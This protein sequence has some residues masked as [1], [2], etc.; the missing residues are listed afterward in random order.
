[1][2]EDIKLYWA[3]RRVR[4]ARDEASAK[5]DQKIAEAKAEGASAEAVHTVKYEANCDLIEFD[6]EIAYLISRRLF[7][8]AYKLNL[9]L[10][11]SGDEYW[12]ESKEHGARHLT[13]EG[14]TLLRSVVRKE[15]KERGEHFRAWGTTLTGVIG[16]LIGLLTLIHNM[17][18]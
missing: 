9:P 11:P 16:S 5:W 2:F 18:K 1:M 15:K 3:L 13:N 8:Q 10:P 4:K 17:G 14:I 12:E 7:A 6:E